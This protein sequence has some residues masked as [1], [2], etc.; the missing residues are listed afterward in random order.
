MGQQNVVFRASENGLV[1]V[2]GADEGFEHIYGQIEKKLDSSGL[3]FKGKFFTAVYKGRKL[4]SEEEGRISKMIA[5]KT[6]AKTVIFEPDHEM[7]SASGGRGAELDSGPPAP[8]A[9]GAALPGSHGASGD[10]SSVR[11][12][13][14]LF[15][16]LDECV[17]RFHRGTLRSG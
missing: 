17:T 12:K 15:V 2:F 3:F 8:A 9:G 5:E 7:G 10:P 13:K 1:I 14:T 16:D 4:S 6:G 11:P